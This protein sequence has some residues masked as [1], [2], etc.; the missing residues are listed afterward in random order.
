VYWS[1]LDYPRALACFQE[2][3]EIARR[4]G[5]QQGIGKAV[6]SMAV[7]YTEQG[8]YTQALSCYSQRLQIDLALKDRLSLAKTAGN[9][10]MVYAGLGDHAHALACYSFLLKVTLELGDRQNVLV[11]TGNMISVYTAQGE[12]TVAGRLSRRAI[13]LGRALNV[14]LY[15]CEFLHARADLLARRSRRA[16]AIT[17]CDEAAAM[18]AGIGRTDIQLPA[19]L[20]SLR[21]RLQTGELDRAAAVDA[22]QSLRDAWPE[23]HQQAAILYELWQLDESAASLRQ[24]TAAL[25]HNLYARTPDVTYHRRY[26]KLTGEALPAPLAAPSP[27]AVVAGSATDLEE[28]VVQVDRLI[29]GL[30]GTTT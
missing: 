8:D 7:A 29:A 24:Q 14:P 17:L 10:G 15:L 27:P 12:Y 20:L 3:L 22:L 2:Q 23:D 9:M 21:L 5:D 13:T 25:Y 4:L 30:V 26:Q 11:A 28:L 6:G 16:E 19:L 1:Q 18:A